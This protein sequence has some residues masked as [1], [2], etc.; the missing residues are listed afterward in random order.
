MKIKVLF[1]AQLREA[2]GKE[3]LWLEVD[4]FCRTRDAADQAMREEPLMPYQNLPLRYA[5]NHEF[6]PADYVLREG[7]ELALLSPVAGG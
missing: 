1:F 7:D 6:Q 3:M 4:A 5:V 2:L